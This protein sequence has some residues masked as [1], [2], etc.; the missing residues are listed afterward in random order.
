VITYT[1]AGAFVFR[2]FDGVSSSPD[3]YPQ[4]TGQ[5]FARQAS[6]MQGDQ[7]TQARFQRFVPYFE[8][9][10]DTLRPNPAIP[11]LKARAGAIMQGDQGTQDLFRR[12]FIYTFDLQDPL[13]PNPGTQNLKARQAAIMVGDQGIQDIQRLFFPYIWRDEV[14]NLMPR[15]LPKARA[16]MTD[17]GDQGT[18]ARFVFVSAAVGWGWEIASYQPQ[19]RRYVPPEQ[20]DQGNYTPI[21]FRPYGW[22]VPSLQ[23][24]HPRPERFGSIVSSAPGIEAQ[25]I[26]TPTIPPMVGWEIAPPVLRAWPT[27]QQRWS[28]RRGS[29]QFGVF[30]PFQPYGWEIPP[31]Q[32]PHP[33]PERSGAIMPSELGIEARF[34][35]TPTTLTWGW[36]TPS[37]MLRNTYNRAQAAFGVSDFISFFFQP[38]GWEI[39][40]PQPPHPRFERAGAIMPSEPGIEAQFVFTPPTVIFFTFEQPPLMLKHPRYINLDYG[41]QG[42]ASRFVRFQPYGW[43]VPPPLTRYKAF[44]SPEIGDQGIAQTFQVFRAAG[45]EIQ[46]FQPPHPRPERA[47]SIMPS[48]PGIEAQFVFTPATPVIWG[49]EGV[50][51]HL[52]NPISRYPAL[53]GHVD[54]AFFDFV[55][56]GWEIAPPQPPHP[57]FEKAGAIMPSE[58]GIEAQFV[59]TPTT[60]VIWG[61][62]IVPPLLVPQPRVH[63][64]G[65][66]IVGDQGTQSPFVTFL[67]FSWSIPS[68]QPGH[69]RPER[70]GAIMV[71]DAGIQSP[72]LFTP[73]GWELAP[74]QPP[75][76]KPERNAAWMIGD[77]GTQAQFVPPPVV[78]AIWGWDPQPFIPVHPRPERFAATIGGGQGT[79]LPTLF[80][81][82]GWEIAPYQ[83]P[84]PRPERVGA[85]MPSELGISQRFQLFLPYGWEIAPFQPPH[86]RAEKAG[87]IMVGDQGTYSVF[88]FVPPPLPTGHSRIYIYW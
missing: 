48:E 74:F 34:V 59:F 4:V 78:F 33:R 45:W 82:Y 88:V 28:G 16:S 31:P 70:A 21:V 5:R 38:Y 12:F 77:Q 81:P 30:S 55:P 44:R 20:G 84:H 3:A 27:A 50:A 62:E 6:I 56:Y 53:E 86:P 61:W 80:L 71:G 26:F 32:P 52:R 68:H 42:T 17:I 41:D 43:E 79:E 18:Q 29:S 87:S 66:I 25:F 14:T 39:A 83:P 11:N 37:Q 24:P 19:Y 72:L 8:D 10:Q 64:R 9:L 73:Y 36:E 7:G 85:I 49:F 60:P 75:H 51:P 67:P 35:F 23:P 40:S 57:R 2:Y 58:P 13:R 47:G 15:W 54:F 76:P 22:E 65:A 1:A 63:R 46:P 69:P